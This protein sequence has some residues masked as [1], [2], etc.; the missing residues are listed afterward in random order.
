M[1]F[2]HRL[3]SL[4]SAALFCGVISASVL[5]IT[6]TFANGANASTT[7]TSVAATKAKP[8]AAAKKPK[9]TVAATPINKGSYDTVDSLDVVKNP[10]GF[11]GKKVRFTGVFSSFDAYAL[12]YKPAFRDAKDYVSVLIRRPDTPAHTIPL[13]ELKMLFP[14]SKS[15]TVRDLEPGDKI[16][17]YGKVFSTALGDPWMDLDEVNILEK[18]PNSKLKKGE[19]N[20]HGL[21]D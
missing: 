1:T 16:E 5:T 4:L 11:M 17:V 6:P 20:P 14:R 15:K 21:D 12:D 10:A 2:S 13:S 18:T 19:A 3:A 9:P 8:K 7:P